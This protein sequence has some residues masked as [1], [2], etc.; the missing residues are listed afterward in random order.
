MFVV[1]WFQSEALCT[2]I[3][4]YLVNCVRCVTKSVFFYKVN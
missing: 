4:E 1:F 2:L 3:K